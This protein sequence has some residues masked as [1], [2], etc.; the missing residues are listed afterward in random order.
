[1]RNVKKALS[2]SVIASSIR[3]T[4]TIIGHR[5]RKTCDFFVS[6]IS[7]KGLL[8]PENIE[9]AVRLIR[10]TKAEYIRT[11]KASRVIA[12]VETVSHLLAIY[13]FNLTKTITAMKNPIQTYTALLAVRPR[14]SI[15][16]TP[17]MEV[18][19]A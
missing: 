5:T 3:G 11:N 12:V 10:R 2:R 14:T 16:F 19:H 15:V 8:H 18:N 7:F 1:M 17:T 4:T 13:P 6:Q 9:F